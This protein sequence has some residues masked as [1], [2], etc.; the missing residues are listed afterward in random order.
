MKVP[1]KTGFSFGLTSGIITTLGMMMGLF[2]GTHSSMV[3][4]GGIL[5][6]A[7]T[8][9]FSDAI[10]MHLSQETNRN[11]S[12]KEI[13]QASVSTFIAKFLFCGIFMV[14]I[15]LLELNT[16]IIVSVVGGIIL[17]AITSIVIAE[18]EKKHPIKLALEH[19]LITVVVLIATYYAGIWVDTLFSK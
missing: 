5:S 10:A 3:V 12:D 14:P 13:W 18:E 2:S 8:D 4:A 6:I 17:L 19:V 1:Y 15:L 16:A 11:L 7:I 9:A